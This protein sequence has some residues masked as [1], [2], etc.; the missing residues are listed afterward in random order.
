MKKFNLFCVSVLV[1]MLALFGCSAGSSE[2]SESA[3]DKAAGGDMAYEPEISEV[4]EDSSGDEG[5][6]ERETANSIKENTDLTN[7]SRMVIYNA[8]IEMEVK[9]YKNAQE[10]IQTLIEDMNGYIVESESY[11]DGSEQSS[12]HLTARVPSD[13]FQRFIDKVEAIGTKVHNKNVTGEDVTEE[14][15]DLES[16]LKAKRAV[17]ER[18]LQ[19]MKDA[20]T[21]KDLLE[22]SNDLAAVQEEIEIITG[23]M[24]YLENQT[25]LSTVTIHFYENN[26]IIPELENSELNTWEKTKKQFMDSIN[27]L[28]AA[29]SGILIFLIGNSPILIL[30][31]GVGFG[32]YLILR[33]KMKRNEN[34]GIDQ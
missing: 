34:K 21:T 22:I 9:N 24:K 8:M 7:T 18:L 29:G 28:L 31:V 16:R 4:A 6:A 1:M 27:F 20:K 32:I 15:K 12:G 11:N 26:V 2:S 13:H 14:Y 33:K 19:F 30:L 17:E 5:K 25:N 23:R 3:G 10:S